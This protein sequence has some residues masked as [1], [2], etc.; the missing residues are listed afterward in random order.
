MGQPQSVAPTI[1]WCFRIGS[2][3]AWFVC[4]SSMIELYAL[5]DMSA[6]DL[7]QLYGDV[8]TGLLDKH[9]PVVKMRRTPW[10]Y[11]DC[12]AVRR[13]TSAAERRFRRSHSS[14][15]KLVWDRKMKSMRSLYNDK[16]VGYLRNEISVNKGNIQGLWRTL[17]PRC[18]GWFRSWRCQSVFCGKTWQLLRLLLRLTRDFLHYSYNSLLLFQPTW[19]V[20]RVSWR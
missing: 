14:A 7:F 12:R 18:T 20:A 2:R 17:D 11:A 16:H 3:G 6:N 4:W 10:F 5:A 13:H 8:L 1:T 15:N 9:C 19:R